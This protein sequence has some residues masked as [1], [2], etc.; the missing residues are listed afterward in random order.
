MNIL[1]PVSSFESAQCMIASG[2]KEIYLGCDDAVYKTYSFTGRGKVAPPDI[3]VL[4]NILE[5]KDIIE[6]AHSNGVHVSYLGNTPYFHNGLLYNKEMEKYYDE[7]IEMGID[8]GADALVIGDIGILEHVFS[9]KYPIKLHASVYL[10]TI[11]RE[12]V[13][14]LI[15]YGVSRV[16]LS[17]HVTIDE[18]KSICKENLMEIEI[19]G[20]LGCSFFNGACSFLHDYGEGVK[21]KFSPGVSCKG[22]Y[23]LKDGDVQKSCNIFDCEASC[24]LCSIGELN[25]IGVTALKV[26]GRDR[27]YRNT[28]EV[29]ELYCKTLKML[30]D[31]YT[32]KQ[33]QQEIPLWWKRVFCSKRTCKYSKNN[34]NHKYAIGGLNIEN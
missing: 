18:I 21:N 26:V 4:K 5:V 20:F 11:N 34:P 16:T 32:K 14:F 23:L 15:N 6:Y 9:K 25:K 33:I 30:D 2:A 17:Y 28:A 24:V 31:G 3:K 12:Q 29:I 7:Y 1:A 27:N 13:K 22:F 8:A 10:K 19:V